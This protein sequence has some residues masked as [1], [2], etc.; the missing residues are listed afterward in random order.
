MEDSMVR[1]IGWVWLAALILVLLFLYSTWGNLP[2]NL[3]VHFDLAGR[4]TGWKEKDAFLGSF[5]PA[6]LFLNGTLG[7]LFVFIGRIPLEWINIPYKA[8]WTSTP[9]RRA[10]LQARL[11]VLPALPGFFVNLVLLFV[12]QVVRQAN[13]PGAPFQFPINLGVFLIL[14]LG[15]LLIPSIFLL[16][17]PPDQ[18]AGGPGE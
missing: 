3:A 12:I 1:I 13:V 10:G 16:F 18:G 9:E 14:S 11:K 2:G 7:L 17:R 15:F 8:R 5:L 6:V 4:P